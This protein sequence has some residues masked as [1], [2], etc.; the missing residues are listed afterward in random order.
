MTHGIRTGS[1]KWQN[2]TFGCSRAFHTRLVAR[3]Y[4]F[5]PHSCRCRRRHDARRDT[6]RRPGGRNGKG[7][8]RKQHGFGRRVGRQVQKNTVD[9]ATELFQGSN[10][11][12]SSRR[13]LLPEQRKRCGTAVQ[14]KRP[15]RVTAIGPPLNFTGADAVALLAD[16]QC[17]LF[18]DQWFRDRL[19]GDSQAET[20][21]AFAVASGLNGED[22][23]LAG[24]DGR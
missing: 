20:V 9:W 21:T 23:V 1:A 13:T 4:H 12:T 19:T 15:G 22:G 8:K 10:E 11:K 7:R 14:H 24:F 17:G 18:S 3:E 5:L 6:S 16:H 2:C